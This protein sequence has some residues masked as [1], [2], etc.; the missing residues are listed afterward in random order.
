MSQT[1][2]VATIAILGDLHGH[3]TLSY[4]LLKR[5]ERETGR[6][7]DCI[8]QV[9]DLGAFPPPLKLDDATA[10]FAK[11]DPDELGFMQYY[12]GTGDA[13]D[14]FGPS[15]P[16]HLRIDAGTYFIKGNHEDFEF[17]DGLPKDDRYPASVDAIGKLL[18]LRSGMV[19]A[20]E[21]GGIRLRVGALGGVALEGGPARNAVSPHYTARDL[22]N[23]A[24]HGKNLDILLTHDV[25]YG[26]VYADAGSRDIHDFIRMEKPRYH[27]CGHYHEDGCELDVPGPT[28]SFLLNEVNFRR[29][30]K[31]NRGCIGILTWPSP[32]ESDFTLLDEPWLREYTR[33]NYRRIGMDTGSEVRD[34][35]RP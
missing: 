24:A 3:L 29:P 35:E 22:Q 5:W 32:E 23:L 34:H 8:L 30:S 16:D 11:K 28:R 10:R 17:L 15:A 13:E 27:F 25:P 12:E 14:V 4:R 1:H 31:L 7:V 2:A 20:I 6:R 33:E 26:A 9:G 21:A 18:Y 19:T